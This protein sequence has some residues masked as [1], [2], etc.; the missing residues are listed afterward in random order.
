MGSKKN[1]ARYLI[2][3]PE[4]GEMYLAPL[5]DGVRATARQLIGARYVT[6]APCIPDTRFTVLFSEW[7]AVDRYNHVAAVL[8]SEPIMGP[9]VLVRGD[10]SDALHGMTRG[11][12]DRAM[13]HLMALAAKGGDDRV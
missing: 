4:S 6:T 5:D 13:R 7:T 9:C 11:A 10:R 3:V 2:V 12:A 1:S 8:A